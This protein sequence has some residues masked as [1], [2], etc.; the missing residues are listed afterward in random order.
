MNLLPDVLVNDVAPRLC[1][2]NGTTPD[3]RGEI[4]GYFFGGE[5]PPLDELEI[6]TSP[7]ALSLEASTPRP[8]D[9]VT[10]TLPPASTSL[11]RVG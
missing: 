10:R 5:V 7:C 11:T 9:S 8:L 4:E 1:V 3:V 2:L 6:S